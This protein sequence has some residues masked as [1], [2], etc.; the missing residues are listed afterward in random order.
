MDSAVPT[1]GHCSQSA[2]GLLLEWFIGGFGGSDGNGRPHIVLFQTGLVAFLV[3]LL[4]DSRDRYLFAARYM[5]LALFA[6]WVFGRFDES[7][8]F[9]AADPCDGTFCGMLCC[10]SFRYCAMVVRWNNLAA[11]L[12]TV[13]MGMAVSVSMEP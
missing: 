11:D 4:A 7:K 10:T 9:G 1:N 2:C 3:D 12:C 6:R 8:L 5:D 13:W